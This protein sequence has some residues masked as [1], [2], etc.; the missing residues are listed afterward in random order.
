MEKQ[1]IHR[2]IRS[3]AWAVACTL[4]ACSNVGCVLWQKNV[5]FTTNTTIGADLDAKP[6]TTSIGYARFEGTLQPQFEGGKTLPVLSSVNAAPGLSTFAS[7]HSFATG[8]A[9]VIMSQKLGDPGYYFGNG[10]IIAIPDLE[11]G[12]DGNNTVTADAV[13]TSL[14]PDKRRPLVFT[15]T[16]NLA[17]AVSWDESAVPTAVHLGYKRKEFALAPLE[18]IDLGE[19]RTLVRLPSL[20]ATA[21]ASSQVQPG[22]PLNGTNLSIQQMFATGAAATYLSAHESIR[23][24][25]GHKV[26]DSYAAVK[27]IDDTVRQKGNVRAVIVAINAKF[28]SAADVAEREK[29]WDLAASPEFGLIR[30]NTAAAKTAFCAQTQATFASQFNPDDHTDVY[31]QKVTKLL[32]K[33]SE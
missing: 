18:E 27:Q 26:I 3:A 21:D 9:A 4:P 11:P 29:Y 16:T 13:V 33:M 15:T 22:S 32:G 17:L 1:M 28:Q 8:S 7:G 31:L 25:M 30:N 20:L 5:V 6:V 19:N 24:V 14:P 2:R 10:T 23:D 12:K